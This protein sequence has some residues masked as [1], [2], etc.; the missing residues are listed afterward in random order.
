MSSVQVF[1]GDGVKPRTIV[2]MGTIGWD[3]EDYEQLTM[4]DGAPVIR[5][6]RPYLETEAELDRIGERM[7][8]GID[9]VIYVKINSIT[10]GNHLIKSLTKQ[11][12]NLPDTQDSE[13]T[14]LIE[15]R[16]HP[17]DEQSDPSV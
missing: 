1:E 8:E 4:P 14:Y 9:P 15:W 11:H 16:T 7:D 3:V 5:L 10:F 13:T 2:M 17:Y 12:K 6:F